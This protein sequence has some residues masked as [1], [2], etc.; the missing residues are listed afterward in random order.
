MKNI[1]D[2]DQKDHIC[3]NVNDDS[4]VKVVNYVYLFNYF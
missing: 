2:I 1:L 3:M 4:R